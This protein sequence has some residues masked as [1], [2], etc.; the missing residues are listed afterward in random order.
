MGDDGW[1]FRIF[2]RDI[3]WASLAFGFGLIVGANS[4]DGVIFMCGVVAFTICLGLTLFRIIGGD[5]G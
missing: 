4:T 5:H 1:H 3:Q 2:P